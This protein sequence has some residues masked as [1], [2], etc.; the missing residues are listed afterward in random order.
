MTPVAGI[1]GAE[2]V[3]LDLGAVSAMLTLFTVAGLVAALAMSL[4]T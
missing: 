3:L 1:R 2:R 4:S